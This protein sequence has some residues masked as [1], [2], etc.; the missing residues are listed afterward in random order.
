MSHCDNLRPRQF[1]MFF[2]KLLCKH[3][4]GLS[5]HFNT[6]HDSKISTSVGT[7]L[8]KSETFNKLFHMLGILHYVE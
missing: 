8:L 5:N 1:A 6:L 3:I 4:G 2:F 7:E